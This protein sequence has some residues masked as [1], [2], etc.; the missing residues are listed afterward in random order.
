MDQHA[1]LRSLR[2]S[3]VRSWR[4][5]HAHENEQFTFVV[6][7]I[8]ELTIK[9]HRVAVREGEFVDVWPNVPN[10]PRPIGEAVVLAVITLIRADWKD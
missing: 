9:G 2:W 10:G 3:H 8:M 1:L 7:G 6:S 5:S 4:K